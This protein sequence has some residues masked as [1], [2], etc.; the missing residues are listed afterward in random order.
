MEFSPGVTVRTFDGQ[1]GIVLEPVGPGRGHLEY[2]Y[3]HP[4]SRGN[5]GVKA[6]PVLMKSGEVRVF[7]STA[8]TE[9]RG[10]LE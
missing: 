8:L 10:S 6:Y 4:T 1:L 3:P 2:T 9:L 7:T 5:A